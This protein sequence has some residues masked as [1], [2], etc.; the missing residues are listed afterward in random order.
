MPS[1]TARRSQELELCGDKLVLNLE[2]D[3]PIGGPRATF[4]VDIMNPCWIWRGVDL[5]N[6]ATLTA[7][8]GQFP[9]NFQIG[10]DRD[11]IHL[12]VPRTPSGELEVRAGDCSGEVVVSL[13]LAPAVE[14]DGVTRLPAARLERRIGKQDLCFTFTGQGL[15][16]MWAVDRVELQP[17]ATGE[18]GGVSHAR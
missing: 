16:P 1:S 8:V 17:S 15:D 5:S 13:S 9:F 2:D 11:T 18:P 3:G 12:R 14:H 7:D 10:K 6:G 4:L